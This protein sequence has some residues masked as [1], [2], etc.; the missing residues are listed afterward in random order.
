MPITAQKLM[1]VCSSME[2]YRSAEDAQKQLADLVQSLSER[3]SRQ[4]VE[5]VT[6]YVQAT[7]ENLVRVL[8]ESFSQPLRGIGERQIGRASCRVRV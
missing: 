4:I 2:T 8:K 5:C 7:K 3:F 1:E 6:S